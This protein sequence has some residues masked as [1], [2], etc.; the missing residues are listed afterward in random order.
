MHLAVRRTNDRLR[1]E[2]LAAHP[3]TG[4]VRSPVAALSPAA[5]RTKDRH[6]RGAEQFTTAGLSVWHEAA[7]RTARLPFSGRVPHERQAC[8]GSV[9][10]A[11]AGSTPERSAQLRELSRN[12]QP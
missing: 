2:R 7:R 6:A 12:P 9:G 11:A 10:K 3:D 8:A 5:C 1:G 4:T